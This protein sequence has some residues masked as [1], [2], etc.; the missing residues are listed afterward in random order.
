MTEVFHVLGEDR[1]ALLALHASLV[2][3]GSK[4]AA[5]QL[6]VVIQRITPGIGQVSVALDDVVRVDLTDAG[7]AIHATSGGHELEEGQPLATSLW[8]LMRRFGNDLEP[9]RPMPFVGDIRLPS[10]PDSSASVVARFRSSLQAA[11]E[12]SRP[13]A[14]EDKQ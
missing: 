7:R 14:I 3:T 6:M 2:A 9:G 1:D 12:A 10:H 4:H 13:H 11:R 5:E 8:D